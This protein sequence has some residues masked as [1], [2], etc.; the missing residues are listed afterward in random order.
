M[1]WMT[2]FEP[3]TTGATVRSE[4]RQEDTPSRVVRSEADLR[5]P[6]G[7][8]SAS[9]TRSDPVAHLDASHD[10]VIADG[11]HGPR[12]RVLP[13]ADAEGGGSQSHP[14]AADRPP[15]SESSSGLPTRSL[16]PVPASPPRRSRVATSPEFLEAC[17]AL[18]PSSCRDE[19]FS[20]FLS[21]APR[22]AA[23]AWPHGPGT[24]LALCTAPGQQASSTIV[25]DGPGGAI[26]SW[27][28]ARSGPSNDIY[29]QHV[30][31]SGAAPGSPS[32][33]GRTIAEPPAFSVRWSEPD[34]PTNQP[35][36]LYLA[37]P[38][39]VL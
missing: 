1:G 36:P 11:S 17:H 23:G 22:S 7:E 38:S 3:A 5:D 13:G 34:V 24:N 12:L 27:A 21:I 18:P 32:S 26:V 16:D 9:T 6:E 31:A 35:G 19:R 2:G 30:L 39:H 29:A 4:P 37:G 20:P 8:S 33:P 28:D 15:R 25:S 14:D 10:D